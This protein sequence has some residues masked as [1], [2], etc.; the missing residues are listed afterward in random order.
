MIDNDM[1]RI[2]IV[3]NIGTIIGEETLNADKASN[4]VVLKHPFRLVMNQDYTIGIG[5]VF[6]GEE[7]CIIPLTT[8]LELSVKDSI[9]D[10]YVKYATDVYGEIIMPTAK[11]I[12]NFRVVK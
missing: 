1:I 10:M 12:N 11:Q 4:T 2:F 5:S 3:P 8:S 9:K 6:L 7:W